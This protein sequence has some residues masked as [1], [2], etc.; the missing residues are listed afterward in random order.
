MSRSIGY[1]TVR[2]LRPEWTPFS[3]FLICLTYRTHNTCINIIR[4]FSITHIRSRKIISLKQSNFR[5]V[6]IMIS[7]QCITNLVIKI[8]NSVIHL[9]FISFISTVSIKTTCSPSFAIHNNSIFAKIFI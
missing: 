6:C 9:C 5:I 8:P 2:R 1:N 7:L 4:P 3:P